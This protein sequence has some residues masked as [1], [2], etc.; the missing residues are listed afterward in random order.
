MTGDPRDPGD[1][2]APTLQPNPYQSPRPSIVEATAPRSFE[3]TTSQVV[4]LVG[5]TIWIVFVMLRLE[6]WNVRYPRLSG[7]ERFFVA[8]EE[9]AHG[10][11]RVPSCARDGDFES[12]SPEDCW[13]FH[14]G[15]QRGLRGAIRGPLS[16]AERAEMRAYLGDAKDQLAFRSFTTVAAFSQY[17]AVLCVALSAWPLARRGR[18]SWHRALGAACVTCAGV[19]GMVAYVREYFGSLGW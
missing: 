1:E 8:S 7:L 12:A 6:V 14:A 16:E 2:G 11:W 4:G 17:L 3:P 5:L 19:C 15:V 13:R 18:R 10:K 9:A